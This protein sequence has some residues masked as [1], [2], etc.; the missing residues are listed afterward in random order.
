M[1]IR[2]VLNNANK[3]LKKSNIR[4]YKLDSEVLMCKVI[5]KDRSYL[6]LNSSKELIRKD[7][8]KFKSLLKKRS[9]GEPIAYLVGKKDFY[10]YQFEIKKDVLIPRPETELIVDEV[11]KL[12]KNKSKLNILDIGVGSGCLLLSILKEKKDFYGTGIDL[13][14]RC[15]ELTKINSSKLSLNN[16][17]KLYKSDVDNFA[18]GKYDLIISNPPYINKLGLKYLEKDVISYEPIVALNGGLDG[19][20]EIRKVINKSS[21]LIKLNGKLI[22]EIAF[23]QKDKVSKLLESKG[24]YINKVLKDLS[25]F[26]RCIVSTKI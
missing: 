16:R 17:V 24:F 15:I 4:T 18:Y 14:K 1:N 25:K 19:I 9:N 11:L 20:S 23:D 8:E 6:I 12:T 7:F 3:Y 26:D 21:E 22:L 5:R 2:A 10:K 13:S